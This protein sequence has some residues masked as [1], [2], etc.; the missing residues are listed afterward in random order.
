MNTDR[1][2]SKQCHHLGHEI[3]HKAFELFGFATSISYAVMDV[4]AGGYTHGILESYFLS[5]SSL[6]NDPERACKS[7]K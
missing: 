3:G 4:C 1:E 7:I 2:I 5:D 6:E